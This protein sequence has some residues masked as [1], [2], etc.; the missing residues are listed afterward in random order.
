MGTCNCRSHTKI[1]IG[2]DECEGPNS[3]AHKKPPSGR[4]QI[5]KEK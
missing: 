5:L 1:S 3:S 4:I 2:V